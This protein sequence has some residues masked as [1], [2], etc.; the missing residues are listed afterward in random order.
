MSDEARRGL[1]TGLMFGLATVFMVVAVATTPDID[2]ERAH[3]FMIA[4]STIAWFV[5]G[6]MFEWLLKKKEK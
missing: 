2:N 4:L 3:A 1:V 5:T 6:I